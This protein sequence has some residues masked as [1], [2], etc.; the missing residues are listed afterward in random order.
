M[1]RGCPQEV[2][3]S[4]LPPT[5]D[6]VQVVFDGGRLLSDL[7]GFYIIPYE[8]SIGFCGGGGGGKTT[9]ARNAK[10]KR[11]KRKRDLCS[12]ST[13]FFFIIDNKII[14]KKKRRKRRNFSDTPIWPGLRPT[15]TT[16]LH[17][18]RVVQVVAAEWWRW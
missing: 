18:L 8:F 7:F 12:L 17:Y 2:F 13:N 3:T 10:T 1:S 4:L 11:V 16:R 9:E 14:K 6:D 15:Y 5:F